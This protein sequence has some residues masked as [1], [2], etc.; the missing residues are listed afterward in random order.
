M[1][2][3]AKILRA[4][5]SEH[6]SKFLRAIR[7]EAKCCKHFQIEWDHSIPLV[8]ARISFRC[9]QNKKQTD[10]KDI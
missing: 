8:L 7:A 2:A 10:D 9:A 6:S 3:V 1:R 4:R 5:A